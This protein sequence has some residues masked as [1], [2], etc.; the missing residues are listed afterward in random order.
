LDIIR[1]II[2]AHQLISPERQPAINEAL[3]EF[4][5]QIGEK[6]ASI[7]TGPTSVFVRIVTVTKN[8]FLTF[9]AHLRKFIKAIKWHT[10]MILIS[11]LVTNGKE[12]LKIHLPTHR[13]QFYSTSENFYS[14]SI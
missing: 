8:F 12:K 4:K 11:V 7:G 1:N 14:L 9:K 10:L 6:L 13:L 5:R 3:K 2:N